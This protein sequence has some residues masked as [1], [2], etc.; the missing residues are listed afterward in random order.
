[1]IAIY[2]FSDIVKN[3][4]FGN[5]AEGDL[6]TDHVLRS[7]ISLSPVLRTLALHHGAVGEKPKNW[8]VAR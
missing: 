4:A 5:I 6:L 3:I 1:M 2:A 7:G 8:A